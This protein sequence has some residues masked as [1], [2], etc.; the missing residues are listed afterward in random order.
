MMRAAIIVVFLASVV[1]AQPRFRVESASLPAEAPAEATVRHAK[2]DQRRAG[3]S[4]ICH[5][6]A[7]EFA[8]ENTLE[9]YR[10]S[11]ELGA[12]GNEIDVRAT[13]DGLLVC[14]HDGT[15]EGQLKGFGG[16]ADY[17]LDE[18]RRIP[19]RAPGRFG[20]ACR[21]PTL[22]E[23]LDLHRRYRGLL[24]LDIK[25]PGLDDPVAELLS[26]MDMWDH[27][28]HCNTENGDAILVNPNYRGRRY[29][30]QLYEDHAE[31]EPGAIGEM[32][33]KPGDDVIVDDPRGVILALARTIGKVS[34][35]P[36][37]PP[38]IVD[39]L[40]QEPLPPTGELL[41]I[42]RNAADWD[43]IAESKQQQEESARRI[44]ARARAADLLLDRNAATDEVFAALEDRVR[45]RSLHRDWRY[46]GLDG[47]MALRSLILL[48]APQAVELA[49]HTLWRDDPDLA[50]VQDPKFGLPRAWAD[51][52]LKQVVFP[53]LERHPGADTEQLCRDYLALEE[54]EA[55]RL[56]PPSFDSAARTLLIIS[57]QKET[58]VELMRHRLRVVRGRAIIECLARA[59]EPW[60]REALRQAA[61]HAIAY[62]Q[63]D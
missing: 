51:F 6:G 22:V 31:V 50:R 60:A 54:G 16:I 29:K 12:D 13:K 14:F 61:P 19:F 21:I 17:T 30:G 44:M 3:V 28:A 35:E 47:E 59:P 42:L 49:R 45:H 40:G 37:V 24:H 23:V 1:D 46:H 7:S 52:R 32:L 53:A 25:Q 20:A 8:H 26:R 57:P 48:H 38:Q 5:R 43:R 27:V 36:V 58:A 15:I 11:F 18:L 34:A 2:V 9:A 4:A 39:G 55:R 63:P 56:G 62:L 33:K 10:A 41:A